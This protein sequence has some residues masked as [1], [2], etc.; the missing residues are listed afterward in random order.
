MIQ[1]TVESSWLVGWSVREVSSSV[2]RWASRVMSS[3]ILGP[4]LVEALA[5]DRL[6]M[7]AGLFAAVVDRQD[8]TGFAQ[9]QP[10]R[11]R[12]ADELQPGQVLGAVVA[13]AGRS[14]ARFRHQ[15]LALVEPDRFCRDSARCSQFTD[16]HRILPR[17]R[18]LDIPSYW[19]V[20]DGIAKREACGWMEVGVNELEC[21]VCGMTCWCSS[22]CR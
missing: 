18:P 1:Q 11:L 14:A 7:A 10:R 21:A 9:T 2:C 19:K 12:P 15:A 22:R 4:D 20:Q 13:V 6:D 8:L 17:I 5:E 16:L 3:A